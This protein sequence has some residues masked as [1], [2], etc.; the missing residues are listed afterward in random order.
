VN[1]HAQLFSLPVKATASQPFMHP[2]RKPPTTKSSKQTKNPSVASLTSD[3]PNPTTH[4]DNS[5]QH[6]M[7]L[8]QH[9]ASFNP[10]AQAS[11]PIGASTPNQPPTHTPQATIHTQPIAI[12]AAAAAAQMDP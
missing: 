5:Q 1:K 11:D 6:Q 12:A 10:A 7:Q 2:K 3:I 9:N 8:S 4:Q